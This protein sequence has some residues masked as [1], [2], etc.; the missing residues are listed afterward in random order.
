MKRKKNEIKILKIFCLVMTGT[1][2]FW[3]LKLRY[4][5]FVLAVTFL[6]FELDK[7][8]IKEK[9]FGKNKFYCKIFYFLRILMF[10]QDTGKKPVLGYLS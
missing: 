6:C 4:G 8:F 5:N 7:N 2:P 9:M 1:G 10:G 3:G